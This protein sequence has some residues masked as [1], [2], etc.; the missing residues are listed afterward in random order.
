MASYEVI[1]QLV[2]ALHD[3]EFIVRHA[4]A[5][6][7]G[8]CLIGDESQ[9]RRVVTHLHRELYSLNGLREPTLQ[10]LKRL[11]DGRRLPGEKWVPLRQRQERRRSFNRAMHWGI[12]G[13]GVA[14]AAYGL[15]FLDQTDM[16]M[17]FVVVLGG[18]IGI[19]AGVAQIVGKPL[20]NPWE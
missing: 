10:S 5:I 6:A 15:A 19:T 3:K 16:L 7:L 17:K 13:V 8:N 2:L 14:L 18:L 11:L 1:E 9:F 4:A 20:R 12:L